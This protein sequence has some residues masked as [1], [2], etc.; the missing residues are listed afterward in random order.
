MST[1]T[2]GPSAAE[3]RPHQHQHI[4][5]TAPALSPSASSSS[6]L[7]L[8]VATAAAGDSDNQIEQGRSSTNEKHSPKH[9]LKVIYRHIPMK[10]QRVC[11]GCGKPLYNLVGTFCSTDCIYEWQMWETLLTPEDKLAFYNEGHRASKKSDFEEVQEDENGK[12][13]LDEKGNKVT[14]RVLRIKRLDPTQVEYVL[15]L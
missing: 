9:G 10:T 3:L 14:K 1:A 13:I 11:K 2:T 7:F 6:S 8:S 15:L 5:P 4:K 12:P